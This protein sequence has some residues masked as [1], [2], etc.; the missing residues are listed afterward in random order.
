MIIDDD[1]QLCMLLRAYL[2][3]MFQVHVEHNLSDA[4]EYLLHH[5]S[6]MLFLDNS[7][8]DGKGVEFIKEIKRLNENAKVVLM[9]GDSSLTVKD[10]AFQAGAFEFIAKPFKLSEVKAIISAVFP[11]LAA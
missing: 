1:E 9:T 7:L 2:Q 4:K 6:S 10:R 5:E 3:R 8:P 11:D